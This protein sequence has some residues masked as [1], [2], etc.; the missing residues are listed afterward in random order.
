MWGVGGR[1]LGRWHFFTFEQLNL[2]VFLLISE[3]LSNH[4]NDWVYLN[5][6]TSFCILYRDKIGLYCT[7]LTYKITCVSMQ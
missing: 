1:M 7:N 2:Q 3:V 5:A 6:N 4:S